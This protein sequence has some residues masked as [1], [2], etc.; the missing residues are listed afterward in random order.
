MPLAETGKFKGET[1][2]IGFICQ[3]ADDGKRVLA[4]SFYEIIPKTLNSAASRS[5]ATLG[6]WEEKA[7]KGRRRNCS[8]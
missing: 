7:E 2:S 1:Q 8:T 4:R 6:S 3:Q 5:A